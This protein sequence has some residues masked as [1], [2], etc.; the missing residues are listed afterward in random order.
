M[1]Q[2]EKDKTQELIEV[3]RKIINLSENA[4]AKQNFEALTNQYKYKTCDTGFGWGSG[5]DIDFV[6]KLEKGGEGEPVQTIV[7]GLKEIFQPLYFI[8]G[9]NPKVFHFNPLFKLDEGNYLCLVFKLK[10]NE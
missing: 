1:E 8:Y 9:L 5:I 10:R 6:C 3:I 2:K 7:E 4:E